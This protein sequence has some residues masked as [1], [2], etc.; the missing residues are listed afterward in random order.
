MLGNI[1]N[2]NRLIAVESDNPKLACGHA[3]KKVV[4]SLMM[5]GGVDATEVM[6]IRVAC[7]TD[8]DKL[9]ECP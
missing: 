2:Q 4:H 9:R 7:Q 5:P 6:V 3:G 1:G 8:S